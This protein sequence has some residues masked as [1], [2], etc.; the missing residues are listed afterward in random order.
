[1]RTLLRTPV[2][3]PLAERLKNVEHISEEHGLM[4]DPLPFQGKGGPNLRPRLGFKLSY[5]YCI[6]TES[7]IDYLVFQINFY[8]HQKQKPFEPATSQPMKTL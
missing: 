6:F 1:M 4:T 7:C 8:D 5:F 2:N 3:V